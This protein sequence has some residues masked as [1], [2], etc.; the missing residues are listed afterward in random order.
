MSIL[1]LV[2]SL[3]W[4]DWV[5]YGTVTFASYHLYQFVKLCLSDADL[6]VIA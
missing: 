2:H 5:A 3:R 1:R 4:T 6:Q